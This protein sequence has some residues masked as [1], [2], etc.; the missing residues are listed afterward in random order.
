MNATEF[1]WNRTLREQW[2]FHWNHQLRDRLD[3]LTDDEYFWSP[4]PDAWSVRPRGTSKAPVQAGTGD[5]TIDFAFPQPDPAPFTTIAWQLGHVVVGVLAARNAAHFGAPAASYEGW[6]Y[7]GSAATAL[8]QLKAQL[9]VWMAGVRDLGEAGLLLPVGEKE[10]AF[11]ELAMADLVLHIQRELIHHLSEVC[12]LRD[13]YA[14]THS[15]TRPVTSTAA[16]HLTSPAAH[17]V[18]NGE[19]R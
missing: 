13:L 8:D 10:P 11:P 3:G 14:H 15:A 19:A 17:P 5:F 1:D 2:E 18:T 4:V 9:D 7:A 12:L 16:G 6:E